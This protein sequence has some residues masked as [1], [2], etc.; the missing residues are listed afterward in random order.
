MHKTS[1][2]PSLF[3]VFSLFLVGACDDG[4]EKKDPVCGNGVIENGE[5]CDGDQWG[6]ASCVTEGF[7]TGALACSATCQLDTAGCIPAGC[8]DGVALDGEHC[9]GA[10]L[11]GKTCEDRGFLGGGTLACNADCTYNIE[12]CDLGAS[13]QY[14]FPVTLGRY[15]CEAGRPCY[16]MDTPIGPFAPRICTE[17]FD[18]L[19]GTTG[20]LCRWSC[21]RTEDCPLE[22]S[23]EPDGAG[24]LVCRAQLCETPY[25]ACTLGN[26]LPG[27]CT[28]EGEAMFDRKV[29][30]ISGARL[31]GESCVF[32]RENYRGNPVFAFQFLPEEFC[33]SGRCQS[34]TDTAETGL[35]VCSRTLCDVSAVLAGTL[36]D[37]CPTGTN[38]FNLSE[39][40]GFIDSPGQG[41][42]LR[43]VDLGACVTVD[44]CADSWPCGT[45]CNVLTQ[46]TTRGDA[47]CPD[48]GPCRSWMIPAPGAWNFI[49]GSILGHCGGA[50]ESPLPPGADCSSDGFGCE[51]GSDCVMADPFTVTDYTDYPMG[52]AT[53]PCTRTIRP[54][55]ACPKGRPGCA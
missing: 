14:T 28:P 6:Q 1:L 31:Q 22:E 37:P 50:P 26:G 35:G 17:E 23:C 43:S 3:M 32:T 4:S 25:E 55:P 36:E 49:P 38:C 41:T 42:F 34:A 13:D 21:E 29:C 18:A 33:I 24:R 19:L 52:S 47:P 53:R 54:A 9:D 48:G 39:L 12:G 51:A 7:A 10:D 8:G 20:T 40:E 27:I 11:R 2:F 16:P 30:R 45:M 46:R 5:T 15:G 44:G